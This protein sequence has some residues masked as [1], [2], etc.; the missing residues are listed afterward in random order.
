MIKK[1]ITWIGSF[2]IVAAGG[3]CLWALIR[4]RD[5]YG[6]VDGRYNLLTVGIFVTPLVAVVAVGL[7]Y[8]FNEK[9]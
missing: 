3:F 1:P 8:Y 2:V 4:Y 6:I 9:T 5:A 7:W